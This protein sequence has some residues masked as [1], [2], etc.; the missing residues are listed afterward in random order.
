LLLRYGLPYGVFADVAKRVYVEVARDEFTIYG[1]KQTR[2]RV[3]VLTGLSRKEVKRVESLVR[4]TD[5]EAAQRYNRAARV[6]SA[7][8]RDPLYLDTS[9]LP[10]PLDVEGNPQSF[11]ALAKKY[12]GDVPARAILDELLRVGALA[13]DQD[14]RAHLLAR[15]YIPVSGEVDKLAILGADVG[16]LISCIDHNLTSPP[17]DAFFQRKVSY[18]NLPRDAADEL[19]PLAAIR[20]QALLEELDAWMA[21]RDRDTNPSVGGAGR[22]RA[23][24]GIYYY[25]ESL[26]E[27]TE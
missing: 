21:L 1:R 7:W 9:G 8:T 17:A 10:R 16:D 14:G 11:A 4:P 2:S 22:A 12:S 23:S 15:A 26:D 19:R 27:D 3:S 6:L 13:L 20:A 18:D 24:V 5:A 25:E